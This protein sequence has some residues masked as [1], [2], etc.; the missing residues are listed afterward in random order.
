MAVPARPEMSLTVPVSDPELELMSSI[1]MSFAPGI[2]SSMV[3]VVEPASQCTLPDSSPATWH[4][5]RASGPARTTVSTPSPR[6]SWRTTG[7]PLACGA[8]ARHSFSAAVARC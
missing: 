1:V 3:G 4:E 2:W 6:W 8:R 7:S 5:A